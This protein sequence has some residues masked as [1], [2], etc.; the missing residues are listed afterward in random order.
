MII[1]QLKGGLG[2]QLF[3]YSL[4]RC[5]S[6]KKHTPLFLD[7]SFFHDKTHEDHLL[8]HSKFML[9]ELDLD[10]TI[11]NDHDSDRL[12]KKSR[13]AFSRFKRKIDP[14]NT[15][16]FIEKGIGFDPK[17]FNLPKNVFVTG[18]FQSEKNFFPVRDLIR[19][20][21]RFKK[22]EDRANELMASKIN[23]VNSVSIHIRRTDYFKND[24]S[25]SYFGILGLNYYKKCVDIMRD[26]VFD[27]HF[28]IFSD[29]IDWVRKKFKISE[30]I[31]IVDINVN[32]HPAQ[33]MRLM[34]L[35]K[36]NIIANS[37]FSWWAAYLN[38]NPDKIVLAPSLWFGT[39]PKSIKDIVPDS[40][41]KIDN[42]W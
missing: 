16:L 41:I 28:F 11:C 40:W 8:P 9:N 20:E 3:Q 12:V 29:D 22:I 6:I 37:S 19:K 5:L 39:D 17:V 30:N 32:A 36:H 13:K 15:C 2:N 21:I 27:P 26:K 4:G 1:M 18:W 24:E 31:T 34:S 38:C 14:Y 23:S 42:Q 7:I 25:E 10:Y 33:D 35:C